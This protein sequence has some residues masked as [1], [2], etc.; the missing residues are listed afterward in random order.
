MFEILPQFTLTK[1]HLKRSNTIYIKLAINF[2]SIINQ[3]ANK[4]KNGHGKN[5][6]VYCMSDTHDDRVFYLSIKDAITRG[7]LTMVVC[8][9]EKE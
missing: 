8:I 1:L 9:A 2:N 7:Y 5:Y 4:D 3:L 6:Q